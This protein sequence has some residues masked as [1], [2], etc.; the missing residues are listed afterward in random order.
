MKHF[1]S[2]TPL[3]RILLSLL[4]LYG[5]SGAV[6]GGDVCYDPL[7]CFSDED[8]YAKTLQRPKAALP[9]TPKEIGTRFLLY[10]QQNPRRHQVIS[11]YNV[12]SIEKSNFKTTR[13]TC[14]IIHG[15]GDKAENSWVS[16][17]C[18]EILGVDDIN[19]IGADW[20]KGSGNIQ[21]YI[22]AAN[23]ARVVGAEVAYLLQIIQEKIN[24]SYSPSNIHIIGHSLGA[25]AAGE[26]GKRYPGIWKITGLDPAHPY[27]EDTPDEVRLDRTDAVF[28]EVIHTDTASPLGVGIR[29]PIGHHDIYPNGGK[30][31]PGCPSKISAIGNFN[32]IVDILA[33]N[34]FRAFYYYT[35]S[36]RQPD[37][38]LA[39]PCDTYDSF[40]AGSCFPCPQSGCPLMGYFSKSSHGISSSQRFYLNTG[41][42]LS[43]LPSWRYKLSVTLRGTNGIQGKIHIAIFATEGTV[44]EYEALIDYFLPGNMYSSF[45]DVG[46][47]L[48]NITHITFSWSPFIFNLFQHQLGAERINVQS[49]KD[50]RT[51]SFYT[52]GTVKEH[53]IQTLHP[54]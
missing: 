37:G 22:Q 14:I 32:A 26:A 31:M 44:E 12:T 50:G 3:P 40:K 38:F 25:H 17:M 19:C 33:C 46:F 45:F 4:I 9:W 34:H 20:R 36:I 30:H 1:S 35:A 10:T 21:I 28:V 6:L 8:P 13:K 48:K 49:G 52:E 41:S 11:A 42:D 53:V 27:F 2:G 51:S 29:K 7:G 15:M 47:E 5:L 16:N 43:N 24:S 18:T 23:N 39:Y 54:C